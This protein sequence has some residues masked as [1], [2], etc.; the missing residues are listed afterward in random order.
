MRDPTST[1][2]GEIDAVHEAY[3]ALNRGDVP[4]FVRLFDASVE[5]IE[6]IGSGATHRGLAAVTQHVA[7]ARATWAE[8]S[9]QPQRFCVGGV[10]GDRV[11]VFVDVRVRLKNE[12]Q[13][14]EG[15]TVDVYT[16]RNGKVIEFRT[17][18]DE[19]QAVQWAGVQVS[20]TSGDATGRTGAA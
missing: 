19:R 6:E 18:G 14:R 5:R 12:T 13:W 9:C 20:D 11:V 10:A 3:A 7:E 8:G 16:F 2:A 17:F 15:R 4:S 1:L